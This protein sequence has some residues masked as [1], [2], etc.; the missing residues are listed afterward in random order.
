MRAA[1]L[2]LW[3]LL[4]VD[5][6]EGVVRFAGERAVIL[7]AGAIGML[8]KEL[9]RLVG[10]AGARA[11]LTRF[12]VAHGAR[13]AEA[14]ASR[15]AWDSDAELHGAGA[16]LHTLQGFIRLAPGD[17]SPLASG[18]A[19]LLSSYEAEQHLVHLGRAEEPVC[20][21]LAGIASG[22]MSRATGE[23]IYVVEDRCI[24]RGDAVC[25]FQGRTRAAWGAAIEEHL[26]FFREGDL[27]VSLRELVAARAAAG[28]ALVARARALPSAAPRGE[29]LPALVAESPAMQRA[30]ERARRVAPVDSTILL[31]G[32]SGAGKERVA[33]LIHD[34]SA[35]ASGPFVAVNCA[36]IPEALLESEL[37][38]HTRGA[39]TGASHD[40]AGLFEAAR[41]G[42]LLLDEV[43]EIPPGM[44]AKLLRA[45]QERQVRRVGENTSRPVDARILAATNRDL[46]AD[47]AAGR[48]R[49]DLYYRLR[50]IEIHLPPLRE[51][52]EDIAPLA[53]ALLAAASRRL[54]RPVAGFT[55][56]AEAALERHVWP[57]NV[58]ELENA[59]EHAVALATGDVAGLDDLPDDVRGGGVAGGVDA[60]GGG[61][62]AR[63]LEEVER[64]AI[65]AALDRHGGNQARAAAELGIGAST[66]YRKLRSYARGAG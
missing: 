11:V 51:R 57:G 53:R 38:G 45:L 18:G 32:E 42:T 39:F 49:K 16:L 64:R 54:D 44:Q 31:T 47:A 17:T 2:E 13:M 15:L 60:T 24:G 23:E 41:G 40:R 46:A 33:R 26:P 48:F 30:L 3:K 28:R 58:R 14:M 37:F 1:D 35:R 10:T 19:T 29:P 4:D 62:P 27:D 5:A 20:W 7:D 6:Q 21:M 8:R 65:L 9:V 61:A 63:T 56:E 52:R 66:L 50:V 55:P 36:A 25:H 12:G 34:A 22:Y 59:V 43:G